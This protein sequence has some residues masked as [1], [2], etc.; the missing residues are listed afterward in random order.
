MMKEIIEKEKNN[1]PNARQIVYKPEP[2]YPL[3]L[4]QLKFRVQCQGRIDKQTSP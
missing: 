4:E 3:Q 2:Q 1:V